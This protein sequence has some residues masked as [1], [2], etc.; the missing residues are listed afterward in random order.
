MLTRMTKTKKTDTLKCWQGCRILGILTF[1]SGTV[2]PWNA[3]YHIELNIY[4]PTLLLGNCVS[5]Y[6][7]KR[8]ENY[9]LKK[10][11]TRMLTVTLFI[12]G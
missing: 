2:P 3:Q 6:F 10:T 12:I 1:A 5:G 9:I 8:N 11:C 7:P 4:L